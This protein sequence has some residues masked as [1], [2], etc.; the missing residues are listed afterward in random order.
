MWFSVCLSLCLLVLSYISQFHPTQKV[1]SHWHSLWKSLMT[2]DSWVVTQTNPAFAGGNTIKV[3]LLFIAPCVSRWVINKPVHSISSWARE[4]EMWERVF[5]RA[6]KTL[7]KELQVVQLKTGGE[8][9]RSKGRSWEISQRWE[10]G[11]KCSYPERV[12]VVE[13]WDGCLMS[14]EEQVKGR[15][16]ICG[17]SGSTW[18]K[19]VKSMICSNINDLCLGVWMPK[20]NKIRDRTS[21][22]FSLYGL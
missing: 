20:R 19:L 16:E 17:K 21:S 5:W 8:K 15:R 10:W 18:N 9:E 7:A 12:G 4:M 1:K 22:F 2:V 13:P 14:V 6:W 11:Q 3:R